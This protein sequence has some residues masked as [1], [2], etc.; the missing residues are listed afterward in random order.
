MWIIACDINQSM[1]K[2][3]YIKYKYIHDYACTYCICAYLKN[4][5]TCLQLFMQC[6]SS[7]YNL[8]HIFVQVN[9]LLQMSEFGNDI[10]ISILEMIVVLFDRCIDIGF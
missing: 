3:I 2:L 9:H 10:N 8:K 5:N 6:H 1:V 7:L 4:L